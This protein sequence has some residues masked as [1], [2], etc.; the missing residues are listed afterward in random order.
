MQNIIKAVLYHSPK[1]I[2]IFNI[3]V[4]EFSYEIIIKKLE[5]EKAK[6]IK[7]L[8]RLKDD[9]IIKWINRPKNKKIQSNLNELVKA[10]KI[11]NNSIETIKTIYR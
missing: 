10:K 6:I 7:Y 9:G 5:S 8:N 1:N 4:D 3:K 2:E 11:I